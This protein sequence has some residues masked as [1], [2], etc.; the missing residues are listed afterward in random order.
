MIEESLSMRIAFFTLSMSMGG[1][2][3]VISS[4]SEEYM[5][6]GH[7]VMLI[8]CFAAD[9]EY[10][11]SEKI[12]KIQLDQKSL[13]NERKIRR[14]IERRRSLQRAIK[15]YIPDVLICFLPEPCLLALSLKHSINC[16]IIISERCDPVTLYGHGI[17]SLIIKN[18]YNRADGCVF[19]TKEAQE[20]FDQ[21]LQVK[22]C[23]IMNPLNPQFE[24]EPYEGIREKEIVAVGRLH[25]QKNYPMLI[26]AFEK[27]QKEESEYHLTIYGE[28]NLQDELQNLINT[29][30]QEENIT[31]Y[32]LSDHIC[33][34]IYK[35]SLFV[36]CSNYEGMPNA[37]LEAMAIGVPV[38]STDCP[39][40]GPRE[41]ILDRVN[42]R[43][44]PLNDEDALLSVFREMAHNHERYRGY[45]LEAAKIQE[46]ANAEKI[47]Q[48]WQRYVEQVLK[49]DKE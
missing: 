29:S 18:M 22:S 42:G 27:F 46:V 30:G 13:Q 49:E 4:L 21:Q 37:L 16:P 39:C 23:I 6:Q 17:M 41:L 3:R 48:M 26:K 38:V 47:C 12:R 14:F 44:I 8:T 33:D 25:E 7:E 36:M 35:A 9:K 20:Y 24:R 10:L 15:E 28:G 2:E 5:K 32:G 43:L 31:L 34:S 45:S 19:Q 1:A 40:G 11:I